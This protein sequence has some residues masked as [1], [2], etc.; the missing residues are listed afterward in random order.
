MYMWVQNNVVKKPDL[1]NPKIK[2]LNNFFKEGTTIQTNKGE[3]WINP[4]IGNQRIMKV[5]A[6]VSKMLFK[7]LLKTIV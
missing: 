3:K 7:E 5:V 2:Y 4:G 1:S 6:R